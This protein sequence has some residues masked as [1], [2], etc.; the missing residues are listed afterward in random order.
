MSWHSTYDNYHRRVGCFPEEN[1][2]GC[3]ECRDADEEAFYD[4]ANTN[5]I[6]QNSVQSVI[7]SKLKASTV[8][9]TIFPVA[10][11][12]L[13]KIFPSDTLAV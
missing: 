2:E 6:R 3:S 8:E 11:L 4:S 12:L 9:V 10:Q 13:P 1:F 7:A 5:L